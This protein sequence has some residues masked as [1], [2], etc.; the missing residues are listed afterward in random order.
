MTAE[1]DDIVQRVSDMLETSLMAACEEHPGVFHFHMFLWW[2][3]VLF[4]S[5]LHVGT[6]VMDVPIPYDYATYQHPYGERPL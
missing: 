4:E 1:I 5:E 3:G 2:E 6:Y